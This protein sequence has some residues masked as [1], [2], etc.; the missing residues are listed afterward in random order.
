[1]DSSP[2]NDLRPSG[3]TAEDVADVVA[4]I[5]AI[6][7][8]REAL[9]Q[10]GWKATIAGNRITVNDDVLVHFVGAVGGA[11]L[12]IDERQRSVRP[13]PRTIGRPSTSV[14]TQHESR[15]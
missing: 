11:A 9:Q 14:P 8:A 10:A 6:G 3:P 7:T 4:G 2:V 1:M 12:V 15:Q 13:R 5:P